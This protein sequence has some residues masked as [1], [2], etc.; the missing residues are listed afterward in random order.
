[1]GKENEDQARDSTFVFLSASASE[2][3]FVCVVVK[4]ETEHA[5][6]LSPWVA[7]RELKLRIWMH[8]VAFLRYVETRTYMSS[9]NGG[10]GAWSQI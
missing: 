1:M 4:R 5:R 7:C 2:V 10:H 6:E 8:C 9:A 3:E